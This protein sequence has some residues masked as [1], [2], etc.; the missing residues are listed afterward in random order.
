MKLRPQDVIFCNGLP[1]FLTDLLEGKLSALLP[2]PQPQQ[3]SSSSKR[4]FS[5][6]ILE[7]KI[8]AHEFEQDL[9]GVL[10]KIVQK[11]FYIRKEFAQVSL[12]H[13]RTLFFISAI[14]E[15]RNSF[16]WS[17]KLRYWH[18][19][20]SRISDQ[21]RL[22]AFSQPRYRTMEEGKSITLILL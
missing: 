22:R 15:T 9:D 17:A 1:Y 11:K 7:E 19:R 6:I 20:R 10:Q 12:T 16:Q 2:P 8:R 18:S 14:A 4:G 21:R 13:T 5:K 3:A